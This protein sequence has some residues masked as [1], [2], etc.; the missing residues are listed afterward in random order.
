MEGRA[1]WILKGSPVRLRKV[2][3]VEFIFYL[4]PMLCLG[5]FLV[6]VTNRLLDLDFFM[7]VVSTVT[8][9]LVTVGIT[10]LCIGMGVV[11]ADFKDVD[12]NRTATSFGALLTMIYAGLAVTAVI[13]LEAYP[14]YRIVTASYFGRDLGRL[15][16]VIAACC[17]AG[18]LGVVTAFIIRPLK[19]GLDRVTELEV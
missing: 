9:V 4:I 8:V 14:V 19:M 15:D 18:V 17:F 16:Y 6:I 7:S 10:S 12:P 3:W 2:L 1:F 13:L 11:H 5:L